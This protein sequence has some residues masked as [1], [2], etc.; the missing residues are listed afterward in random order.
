MTI[1]PI[2]NED[3][4]HEIRAKHIG[5]SE[6][7]VLFGA[8]PFTTLSELYFTKRGLLSGKFSSP[9][10]EFGKVMEP[11]IAH[12]AAAENGWTVQQCKEYHEHPEYPWLGCSLDY[13]IIESE[14]GESMAQVKNVQNF[15]P[16]WYQNRAPD[17][18]EFQ[19]QHELLVANAA[20]IKAGRKPFAN[21]HIVSLHAGNPEDIRVM[22]RGPNEK[23]HAEIIKRST[24]FWNDIE[25]G[26]EPPV[27]GS[28]DYEHITDLFK[29][30]VKEEKEVLM[31]TARPDIDD[32]VA[33]LTIAKS[34]KKVAEDK[35]KEL[36]AKLVRH[37]M[38]IEENECVG[39]VNVRTDN[40]FMEM[41][42]I[43]KNMQAKEAHSRTEY[44]FKTKPIIK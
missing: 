10:M 16:G 23:A 26:N 28:A 41:K 25:K 8:S 36:K 14:H 44:H 18:V 12:M 22:V 34:D 3:Q 42:E 24:K 19:V 13:Y 37:C 9:L 1:T 33:Q 27:T 2:T 39:Y 7:A 11:I 21:H 31:L 43:V 32:L 29:G 35:E 17:H 38:V 30:S 20:R 15:A 4:W 40:Y 5:A 6:S